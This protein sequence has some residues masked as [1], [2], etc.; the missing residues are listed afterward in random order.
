MDKHM[1]QANGYFAGCVSSLF[2]QVSDILFQVGLVGA[3]S[4]LV[5]KQL[6]GYMMIHPGYFVSALVSSAAVKL[7]AEQ[8]LSLIH[9]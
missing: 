4:G 2:N 8:I 6:L 7:G 3:A 9:I 1:V 5:S